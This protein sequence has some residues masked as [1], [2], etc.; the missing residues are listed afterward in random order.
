MSVVGHQTRRRWIAVSVGIS[1]LVA[2]PAVTGQALAFVDQVTAPATPTPQSLVRS[3]LRSAAVPLQGLAR[4]RGTLGLPDLTVFGSAASLLGQTNTLR[5]W[6]LDPASWRVDTITGTGETGSYGLGDQ[7]VTWD[8]ER[9]QLATGPGNPPVRLPRADDL[10]PPQA[11][12]RLLSSVGP[13]DRLQPI[14]GRRI[15]GRHGFGLRIEPSDVRSTLGHV[16]LWIDRTGVPLAISAYDRTGVASLISSFEEVQLTRPAT[17]VLTPPS[18]PG[19][20]LES[21]D[22]PDLVT[23]IAAGPNRWQLPT[24]LAGLPASTTRIGGATSYGTGLV[25]VA[26]LTLPGRFAGR[27]HR[28]A[29]QAGTP[30][31]QLP[32]GEAVV[33]TSPLLNIV[34]A[35]GDDRDHGYLVTGL[36]SSQLLVQAV[37]DLLAHPPPRQPT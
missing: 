11:A 34:L 8:Y 35:R 1:L 7:V 20:E 21:S 4:S 29:R 15:A 2:A 10:L 3:A 12:R 22:A 33:L 9:R 16:D 24:A 36:V 37:T 32:G 31:L 28:E 13:Q 5:V 30:E 26:V 23:R 27:L 19:A 25:T 14:P 6:W 17:G 18:P